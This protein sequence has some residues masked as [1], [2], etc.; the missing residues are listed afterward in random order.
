MPC[1]KKKSPNNDQIKFRQPDQIRFRQDDLADIGKKM[2][3]KGTPM[4]QIRKFTG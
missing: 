2:W 1:K 3:P 4:K